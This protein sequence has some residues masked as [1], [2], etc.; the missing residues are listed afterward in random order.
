MPKILLMIGLLFLAVGGGT[1]A[2]WFG[3]RGEPIPWME[4]SEAEEPPP[5]ARLESD[6]VEMRPLSIPVMDEGRVIELL[7]LVVSLEVAGSPGLEAVAANRPRLR[8]AM[9]SE[10]H[11]LYGYRFVRKGSDG[12]RL[13]R[14]RLFMAGREIMGDKLRG[15]YIQAVQGR[16][17]EG[18]S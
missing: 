4:P 5:E 1:G 3:M 7:T 13:V 11:A 16:E 15:V 18:A 2:W 17:V 12:I 14:Q 8:D 9:L 6:Y 10:L